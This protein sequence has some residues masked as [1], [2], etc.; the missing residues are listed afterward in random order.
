MTV[1]VIP[2]SLQVVEGENT[3]QKPKKW[4]AIN[5]HEEHLREG[6]L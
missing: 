3:V 4:P 1:S 5:E 2:Q 6:I